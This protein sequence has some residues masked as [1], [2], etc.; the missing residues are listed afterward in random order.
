M[1]SVRT[2]FAPS[3]TGIM[4]IG[5]VRAALLNYLFARQQHGSFALRIEDTD[6]QRNIQQGTQFI[7]K[8]LNWL[9]LHFDDGPNIG[10]KYAPYFQSE[11]SEIYKKYLQKLQTKKLVYRCFCTPEELELRRNR[12]IAMKKAPR[13]EKTCLKLSES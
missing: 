9:G 3:P 11:R 10:G 1:N 12:Q 7:I 8:H 2:R 6:Q 5:N 13:Y 4:H